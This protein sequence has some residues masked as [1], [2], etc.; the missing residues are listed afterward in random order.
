MY[1]KSAILLVIS[2]LFLLTGV[3]SCEKQTAESSVLEVSVKNAE[4]DYTSGST[5]VVVSASGSWSLALG[6]DGE[7]WAVLESEDGTQETSGSGN[8]AVVLYYEKNDTESAR[9]CTV[10]LTS[11]GREVSCSLV[12]KASQSGSGEQEDGGHDSIA[13]KWLELPATASSDGLDYYTHTMTVG[14]TSVRNYT[15]GYDAENLVALWVAYPL[16]KGLIGSGGRTDNWDYDPD[17]P[18]QEQPVLFKG[19]S[20]GDSGA[21]YDRG[22]Q[23]PS[24]DR[25]T[26]EANRQTFYFTNMTPQLSS[27]NQKIWANFEAKVRSWAIN[28][29][30]LYVVTGCVVEGSKEKAYDN[31]GRAVTVPAAYFKALLR[32]SAT[33]GFS[34]YVAAG[35]YLEHKSY[36][37]S[38]VDRS[39][40]MSIRELEDR[41]GIDFFVNLETEVGSDNYQKIEQQDPSTVDWWWN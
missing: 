15:F 26:K 14:G 5:F 28:S 22:H 18:E 25:L 16:N 24:A 36:S 4:A 3:S 37:Q 41:T 12:Q 7:P 40:C 29:D 17:V 9:T 35:F 10:S 34:G 20:R 2:A 38:N 6:F 32:K 27:F 1:R 21:S 39:M 11:G 19:F 31:N 33:L 8:R 13:A 30:T 23:L